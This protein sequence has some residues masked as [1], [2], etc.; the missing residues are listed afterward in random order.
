M[1]LAGPASHQGCE[2]EC[3]ALDGSLACIQS[4]EDEDLATLISPSDPLEMV[5]V[6]EY[7]WPIEPNIEFR[8][9]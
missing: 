6:G 1:K 8:P 9:L 4:Q 2:A 5:W 3:S 7:Q